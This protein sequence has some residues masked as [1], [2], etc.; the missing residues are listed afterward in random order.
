MEPTT[1]AIVHREDYNTILNGG[2]GIEKFPF[3][4]LCFPFQV[5]SERRDSGNY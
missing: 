5:Q 1:H 2:I 4:L 3:P